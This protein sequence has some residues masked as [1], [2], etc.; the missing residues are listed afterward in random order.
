MAEKP[1]VV[2]ILADDMGYGD[3]GC[4]SSASKIPTPHLD[5]LATEGV[6][7][8]DAH[9]PS[10]VCTPTRYA[11]LTGRYCWRSRLRRGV[12]G[13]FSE[14]LI[15]DGR[16][17]AASMLQASGYHTACIGKWHLGLDWQKRAGAGE[18]PA[19]DPSHGIDFRLPARH[20]P[21]TVGFDAFHGIAAS[22]D[23][24]PYCY[25]DG[26]RVTAEL[27]RV[28]EGSP[29]DAFWRRGVIAEDFRHDDVLPHLTARA[30]A[31]IHERA[32][33]PGRPF[34]L[35]FALPAPHT[36]ILP[37]AP[38][39]GKSGAGDYGDFC[40]QVDDVV[41]QVMRAL[42]ESGTAGNTL[43]L[44]T[45]DNGPE[46]NAY[47]RILRYRH[48]SMGALR[49]LKRDLWEGGHRVPFLARWPGR[50]PAGSE[51]GQTI[52]LVDFLATA[53][54]AAGLPVP[55]GAGEDS[56]SALRA[57]L[58]RP[59]DTARREAIV[60]HGAQG[61]LAIRRGDWVLVDASSGDGNGE[62]EWFKQERGYASHDHPGELFHLGDD[63]TEASN[64]Y[65]ERPGVVAELQ[66][67]LRRYVGEGR[68][69]RR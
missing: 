24:P 37:Q 54:D 45:S 41:G 21:T 32:R 4:Y 69:V 15:E 8:T 1:N 59:P 27:D 29:W 66:G 57:L 49:G 62:P 56:L 25:V 58:G 2:L 18:P 22:L 52:S 39:R 34:F 33:E 50:I 26:D 20:G 46:R 53:A 11:V 30:I 12:L 7:L 65:G 16:P 23:M 47:E 17:T 61:A 64:L 31:H 68:S 6:R 38:F 40:V 5:R 3:L 63:P 28:I 42:Q 51:S 60:Y 55:A 13:G 43:L 35:Y 10:A 44:F 48:Y 9:A 67:L 19:D 36:P 14:H